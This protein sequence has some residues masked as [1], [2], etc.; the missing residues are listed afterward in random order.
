MTERKTAMKRITAAFFAALLPAL[1]AFTAHAAAAK[2]ISPAINVLKRAT[3]LNKCG[4]FGETVN[5]E[6][7]DYESAVGTDIRYITVTSL[8][9]T[10][11]GT[12]KLNGINVI[13]GQTV[14]AGSLNEMTF[15]PAGSNALS[16]KFTYRTG[17]EGWESTDITCVITFAAYRNLP[18]VL[19]PEGISVFKNASFEYA[20]AAYDPDGDAVEYV[21]D[22]YPVSGTFRQAS[23]KFIY[24]PLNGF[25]GKDSLTLH[26]LD[27]Y[28]NSS[29]SVTFEITISSCGIE[30][31][32]M[33]DSPVHTQAIALAEKN[34]V[35]YTLKDGEYYFDPQKRVSRIDFTVMA[36]SAAGAEAVSEVS[37]LPFADL[38]NVSAG[39]KAY[40]AKAVALGI[41]P[42]SV[43]FRPNEN[44][45]C[46][47][48]AA[49]L[50]A[51]AG[52][53]AQT[54]FEKAISELKSKGETPL[55]REDSARILYFLI[56]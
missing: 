25:T 27:E 49:L 43:Y 51:L 17:A 34:A 28:G 16:A 1:L 18:P 35:S 30:F 53:N 2:D 24:T 20:F 50:D 4:V 13:T 44:I 33:G 15:V 7:T 31:A 14:A 36:L 38:D 56:K 12:L 11:A 9:D 46:A 19:T 45:S 37:L 22:G 10:T 47:E 23:G 42:E 54:G 6:K 5:F 3:V 48:A 26:A 52:D 21:I 8:P 55:T 32:D 41:A 40:L 29:G 39:K